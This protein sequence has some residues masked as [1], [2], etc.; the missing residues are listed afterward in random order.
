MLSK[1]F[2]SR[3]IMALVYTYSPIEE[4]IGLSYM[5]LIGEP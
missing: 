5:Y 4:N 3:A 2:T 1:K